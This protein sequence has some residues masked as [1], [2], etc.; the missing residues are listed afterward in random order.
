MTQGIIL[1]AGL[2]RRMEGAT[3]GLP[4]SL[5][6]VKGIPL[7]ERNIS[8]MLEAGFERV[9]VVTGYRADAFAYLPEKLGDA[10][11]L[12]FNSF[13]ET[14]NTISSLHA[15]RDMLDRESYITTADIF[16][17]G[18]PYLKYRDNRCF[19]LLRPKRD[20]LK[21][22]WIAELDGEGRFLSVDKRGLSGHS[23]TG[24][25]HWTA[26]GCAY[27]RDKLAAVDLSDPE[28]A[29]QYWD[30]IM[31]PDLAEFDLRSLILESDDEIYE[32]DDLGD[33]EVFEAEEGLR[34]EY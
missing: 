21:P 24:I 10:V 15:A 20:Y 30:E 13:F 26:D 14:S 4:K 12:V 8:Y 11:E 25:S 18:N 19:Y 29:K 17:A 34:V 32:F 16:L 22:D 9:V 1:A 2:G 31:L 6:S 3:G 27:L 7:I 23:Y 5:M 28:Q 33:I